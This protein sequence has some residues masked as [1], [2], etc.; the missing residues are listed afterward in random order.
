MPALIMVLLL[1]AVFF[2]RY[3]DDLESVFQER[4][5]AVAHQIG[6]AAEYALFSGSHDTLGKLA[7]AA[8]QSDPTIVAV[9]V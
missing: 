2:D 3:Q 6:A 5:Y 9:T 7:D 1:G 4:G 8:R